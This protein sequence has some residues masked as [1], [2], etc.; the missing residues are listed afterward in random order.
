[1]AF[2]LCEL[3]IGLRPIAHWLIPLPLQMHRAILLAQ[4]VLTARRQYDCLYRQTGRGWY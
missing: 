1:M 4:F 2:F 3:F